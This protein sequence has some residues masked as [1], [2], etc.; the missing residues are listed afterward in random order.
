MRELTLEKIDQSQRRKL[1]VIIRIR[2]YKL[3]QTSKKFIITKQRKRGSST[4]LIPLSGNTGGKD[5]FF[6]PSQKIAI[7]RD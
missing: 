6:R 7:S 5:L 2:S 3:F 1:S 4:K